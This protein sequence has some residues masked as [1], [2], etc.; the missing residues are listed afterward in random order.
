MALRKYLTG[1][2]VS[3]VLGLGA[4]NAGAVTF[5]EIDSE[6]SLGGS[7]DF[8]EVPTNAALAIFDWEETAFNAFVEFSSN[9]TFDFFFLDYVVDGSAS[10]VSA[11]RLIGPDGTISEMDQSCGNADAP[12]QGSCQLI[13]APGNSGGFTDIASTPSFT[14]PLFTD[15]AAG[16]Y[17][18]GFFESIDPEAGN[19]L[20]GV[21]AV[22]LPAGLALMLGGLGL[23]GFIARRKA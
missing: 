12:V 14:T 19:A 21:A 16:T 1:A 9:K 20:F 22:P 2:L 5:S 4:T 17:T 3:G 13:T 15:L 11:F 6:A 10:A 18:L 23:L 7:V 8:F